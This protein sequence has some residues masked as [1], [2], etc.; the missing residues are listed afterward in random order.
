M[1]DHQAFTSW[2]GTFHL[3][4]PVAHVDSH[5]HSVVAQQAARRLHVQFAV[6]DVLCDV[7]SLR[8]LPQMSQAVVAAYLFGHAVDELLRNLW[9]PVGESQHL[10]Q[11]GVFTVLLR[12]RQVEV[13]DR[14]IFSVVQTVF[15][16]HHLAGRFLQR[17]PRSAE[18]PS[19]AGSHVDLDAHFAAV[20]LYFAEHLHPLVAK[21]RDVVLL[22]TLHAIQ[23]S[24]LHRPDAV[25]G[26]LLHVP[27]QV[28]AVHCRP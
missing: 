7:Y 10:Q 24:Y 5:H 11:T 1:V 2:S 15:R 20:L 12:S 26:I 19:C 16:P 17:H 6:G 3:H 21:E 27:A 22:V 13:S 9:F 8:H 14:G 4:N 25:V 18:R 23:R 28:L